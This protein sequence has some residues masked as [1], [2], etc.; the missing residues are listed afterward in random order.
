MEDYKFTAILQ[1]MRF[2]QEEIEDED[3][4]DE[5]D[6]MNQD[7][8]KDPEVAIKNFV[9]KAGSQAMKIEIDL[10]WD[11]DSGP[12]EANLI[13][14][15]MECGFG[16]RMSLQKIWARKGRDA[17]TSPLTAFA[18]SEGN[19]WTAEDKKI[20]D[21][22]I[23]FEKSRGFMGGH[24]V[25]DFEDS[26]SDNVDEEERDMDFVDL[27]LAHRYFLSCIEHG[28]CQ[29]P[30]HRL[31]GASASLDKDESTFFR[32]VFDLT[33]YDHVEIL[34]SIGDDTISGHVW[35]GGLAFAAGLNGFKSLAD[36]TDVLYKTSASKRTIRVLELGAGTGICSHVIRT[37][38]PKSKITTTDL[39]ASMELLETHEFEVGG[40]DSEGEDEDEEDKFG[41]PGYGNVTLKALEWQ[42]DK[43]LLPS[44][45]SETEFDVVVVTDCTY[46]PDN[47]AKLL[48]T[49]QV[50]TTKSPG[51]IILYSS[52]RRHDSESLFDKMLVQYGFHV[53]RAWKDPHLELTDTIIDLKTIVRKTSN[54]PNWKPVTP[55][56]IPYHPFEAFWWDIEDVARDSSKHGF[57]RAVLEQNDQVEDVDSDVEMS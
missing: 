51:A 37:L 41:F 57:L 25:G 36:T 23:E 10:T 49:L 27:M 2:P 11:M 47:Y 20:V 3:D 13:L 40:N 31:V 43:S 17:G 32:R 21:G 48:T 35:D 52:K 28:F 45:L 4:D 53:V 7:D 18:M 39:P 54:D 38:I 16:W 30:L 44:W 9:W 15:T 12:L 22:I 46:N 6:W 26:D 33:S 34:E 24:F 42:E 8:D 14:A 29:N 1:D 50:V 5:E 56:W 19:T 55:D